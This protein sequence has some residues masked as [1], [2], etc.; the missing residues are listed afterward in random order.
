MTVLFGVQYN[1]IIAKIYT[2][3]ILH[4]NIKGAQVQ[5][6]TTNPAETGVWIQL[7]LLLQNSFRKN[8][9]FICTA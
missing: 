9:E 4:R 3:T 5:Q 6:N 2:M 1:L 8:Y 7:L